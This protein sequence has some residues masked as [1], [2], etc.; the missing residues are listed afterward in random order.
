VDAGALRDAA[1]KIDQAATA[2][3]PHNRGGVAQG[4]V[5]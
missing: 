3:S 1:A 5:G 4:G 2:G